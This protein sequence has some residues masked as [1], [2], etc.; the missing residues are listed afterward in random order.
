MPELMGVNWINSSAAKRAIGYLTDP[1]P[2]WLWSGDGKQ[3]IWCNPAARLF[4]AKEKRQGLKLAAPAVPIKGQVARIIRL[5]SKGRSSLSRLQF[6]V[7]KK[8]VSATCTC[9]SLTLEN[10][11]DSLLVVAV[12]PI[13]KKIMSAHG[14]DADINADLFDL[15]TSFVVLDANGN[16]L[17]SSNDRL[18]FDGNLSGSTCL[19]AGPGPAQLHVF[20]G[21]N[22]EAR[23]LETDEDVVSSNSITTEPEDEDGLNRQV[24]VPASTAPSEVP[25]PIE[26]RD[27]SGLLGQLADHEALYTPLGP[28]DDAIPAGI[29]IPEPGI[30]AQKNIVPDGEIAEE[31]IVE[32]NTAQN[33]TEASDTPA[34]WKIIGEGFEP[35]A[36]PDPVEIEIAGT[37]EQTSRYNFEELSRILTDRVGGEHIDEEEITPDAAVSAPEVQGVADRSLV[38]LSDENLVLNRLPLGILIFRDQDI[39]FA[40]KALTALVG[41]DSSA[42]LR[43]AGLAAVFPSHAD[44]GQD[45]GPVTQ[46]SRVDGENVQVSAR[47]QSVSWRGQPAL[48]LSA[49]GEMTPPNSEASVR[50]FAETLAAVEGTGFMEITRSGVIQSLSGRAA[51]MFGRAPEV[52]V[53]RPLLLLAA[54]VSA[55]ALR[56]FLEKPAKLAE[57]ERPSVVIATTDP[58]LEILLFAEGRAGIVSGYFGIVQ[59]VRKPNAVADNGNDDEGIDPATL[60]RLSRGMRRPLNTIIGFS[61]LIRTE[62]FGPIENPRYI[63]YAGDVKGAGQEIVDVIDELDGFVRLVKGEYELA[64]ADFD[65]GE[66]LDAAVARIRP[67]AGRARVLVRSAVSETLPSIR[68]DAATLQQAILNLLASALE[69]T[70]SGGQVVMSAQREDDGATVI[71]VKDSARTQSDLA[72]RF[73]VF[74]DGM[75]L[76]GNILKPVQSSVG[77]TLT[78]SLLAVNTCKLSVE[79]NSSGGTMFSLTI[80]GSITVYPS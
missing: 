61:E 68:A 71:H 44:T 58:N 16:L 41:Y 46:L 2:A 14:F 63:E 26:E 19:E 76:N 49:R 12:D 31:V 11:T 78:R 52:L 75:D 38:N 54:H 22:T 30:F 10:G 29:E 59:P 37:T 13:D 60:T 42:R 39:L 48:M 21:A 40:N 18:A 3:L 45:V 69:Q 66:L 50:T 77:L 9:T 80:P 7:G 25:E 62:A 34:L 5:G 57:T 70:P 43:A 8:P 56:E 35:E 17:T 65:L 47:L 79:A 51:E 33:L 4:R 67:E 20:H 73:V 23:T 32:E 27:L 28:Q 64:P 72:E 53:G 55:H 1:R 24:A 36:L 15:D 74:R 6:L